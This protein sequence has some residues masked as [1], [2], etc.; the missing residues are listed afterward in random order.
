MQSAIT[1]LQRLQVAIMNIHR[2]YEISD[3]EMTSE[4]ISNLPT[5][6][7]GFFVLKHAADQNFNQLYANFI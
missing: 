6:L 3:L 4:T 1:N 5:F 7:T 2:T